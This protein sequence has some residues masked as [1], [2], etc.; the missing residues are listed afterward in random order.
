ML[1]KALKER[2]IEEYI[3]NYVND[4]VYSKDNTDNYRK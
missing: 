1:E 2:R 4:L 3:T